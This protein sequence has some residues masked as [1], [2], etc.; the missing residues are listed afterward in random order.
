MTKNVLSLPGKES[1]SKRKWRLL[2]AKTRG[3]YANAINGFLMGS[4][5]ILLKF[6]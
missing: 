2:K 4:M 6:L 3:A 5:V 1:A